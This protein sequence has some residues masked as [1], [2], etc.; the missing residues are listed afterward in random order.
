VRPS[1]TEPKLK[2]YVDLSVDANKAPSIREKETEALE[3]ARAIAD[4]VAEHAGLGAK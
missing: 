4:A 1:G 3:T 2:I